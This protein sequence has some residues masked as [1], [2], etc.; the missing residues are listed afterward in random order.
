[1]VSE[2]M[3]S[4]S[5]GWFSSVYGRTG[6]L[7]TMKSFGLCCIRSPTSDL[8]LLWKRN[9]TG[10]CFHPDFS[11]IPFRAGYYSPAPPSQEAAS[12]SPWLVD[13]STQSFFQHLGGQVW[14][15]WWRLGQW[16][17]SSVTLLSNPSL[18]ACI[19]RI[20]IPALPI[21]MHDFNLWCLKNRG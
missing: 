17:K 1:M 13:W 19:I 14:E 9:G 7:C 21:S 16:D 20:N 4:E 5:L 10:E 15:L 12:S 11:L 8:C 2:E 18:A 6:A 3:T